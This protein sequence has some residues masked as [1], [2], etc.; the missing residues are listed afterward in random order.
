MQVF[1]YSEA[2]AMPPCDVVILAMKTTANHLLP[3]L[4]PPVV[5]PGGVVL[6]LQNGLG[7]EAQVGPLPG[8]TGEMQQYSTAQP[9]P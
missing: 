5:R 7:I 3:Q 1:A 8:L 9:L 6:V 4:L 2:S